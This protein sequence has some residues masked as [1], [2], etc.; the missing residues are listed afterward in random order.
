[1]TFLFTQDIPRVKLHRGAGRGSG[2]DTHGGSSHLT[3]QAGRRPGQLPEVDRMSGLENRGS[4]GRIRDRRVRAG[5][6]P[7]LT[8]A[9]RRT[10][11]GSRRRA[12]VGRDRPRRRTA[13]IDD[14]RARHGVSRWVTA[15]KAHPDLPPEPPGAEP[16]KP[17]EVLLVRAEPC[18]ETPRR[19]A[20]APRCGSAASRSTGTRSP[21][22]STGRSSSGSQRTGITARLPSR[23]AGRSKDHTPRYWTRASTRC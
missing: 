5:S 2:F 23:R 14:G 6:S 7:W 22:R 9:A 21:M 8:D 4:A 10:A 13:P 3:A 12:E 17:R 16:L 1:M 15:A 11:R 18:V 20:P 19:A